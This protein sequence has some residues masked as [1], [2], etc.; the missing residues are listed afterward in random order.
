MPKQTQKIRTIRRSNAEAGVSLLKRRAWYAEDDGSDD[1]EDHGGAE[2]SPEDA[3]D[4]EGNIDDLPKWA[5]KVIYDTR[6]E[7][8]K[9]RKEVGELRDVQRKREQDR[10]EENGEFKKLAE[11]R[12]SEITEL[13]AY[14][15][16]FETLESMI[17]SSNEQRVEDIPETLRSIVPVDY[18]PDKLAAWLDANA[19]K[20]TTP[21]APDFNAGEGGGSGGREKPVKL[22]AQQEKMIA[23]SGIDRE[24]YIARLKAREEKQRA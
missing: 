23:E 5:Q 2:T 16:R 6:S 3:D 18:S 7:A 8:K 19:N 12:L 15:D 1:P 9:R 14:K 21:D 24:K 20:L 13:T 10:L 4:V 11:D 17:T 22:D